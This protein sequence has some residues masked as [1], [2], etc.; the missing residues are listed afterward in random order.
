MDE[1]RGTW[2]Y[3][4]HA[5]PENIPV[6]ELQ[7]ELGEI[8]FGKVRLLYRRRAEIRAFIEGSVDKSV[9]AAP[10][11]LKEPICRLMHDSFAQEVMIQDREKEDLERFENWFRQQLSTRKQRVKQ[12][13]NKRRADR[14]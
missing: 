2:W 14:L 8:M 3:L 12:R 9:D 13:I 6:D 4:G 7:R 5:E 10:E 11:D 1:R